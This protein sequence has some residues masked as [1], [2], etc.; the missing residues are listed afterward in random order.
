[1][2]ADGGAV[3]KGHAQ[4]DATLLDQ[5]EQALPDVEPG[6][7]DESSM[8]PFHLSNY[9]QCEVGMRAVR[10]ATKSKN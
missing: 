7:A 9:I 5:I 1:V 6:P 3:E 2:R 10:K 4:R 8:P